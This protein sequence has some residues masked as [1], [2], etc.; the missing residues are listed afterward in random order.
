MHLRR[1]LF[2]LLTLAVA[3]APLAAQRR[4]RSPSSGRVHV[5][6][7]TRRDGRYVAPHARAAPRGR[8]YVAPSHP[9][10]RSYSAPKQPHSYRS[11]R[12]H[13]TPSSRSYRAPSTRPKV[14][15]PNASRD[16]RGRIKRSRSARDE[17]K[18]SSG[19][20]RGRP[21]YVVDH[22][23]PLCAGGAD[24]PSNMQWQTT[25]EAKVKDS[26]ERATCSQHRR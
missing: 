14:S 13:R 8:S 7:Y 6:G 21:G 22:I 3:T 26:Q 4:S 25:G 2:A 17:F 24:A 16:S 19:Y 11:P 9:P 20:P 23:V 15:G 5:R 12:A 18:R 10:N 1:I